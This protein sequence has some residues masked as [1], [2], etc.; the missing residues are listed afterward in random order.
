MELIKIK[1]M[2]V[3]TTCVKCRAFSKPAAGSPRDS[4]PRIILP[5]KTRFSMPMPPPAAPLA[6]ILTRILPYHGSI[7]WARRDRGLKMSVNW[8]MRKVGRDTRRSSQSIIIISSSSRELRARGTKTRIG[9]GLGQ[10]RGIKMIS[11]FLPRRPAPDLLLRCLG[12][13]LGI[14]VRAPVRRQ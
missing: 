10:R 13:R 8:T 3:D 5:C 6:E 4:S 12:L 7:R 11:R 2:E 9:T 1:R 14:F